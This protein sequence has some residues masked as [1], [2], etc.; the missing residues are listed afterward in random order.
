M[1]KSR[2]KLAVDA[3]CHIQNAHILGRVGKGFS[4]CGV[5][6]LDEFDGVL[7]EL[8][9][10]LGELTVPQA[11][12]SGLIFALDKGSEYSRGEIEVWMDSEFIVRQMNGTYA[13]RKSHI[14][15]FYDKVKSLE[16]RYLGGVKYFH[17]PRHSPLA[18]R[19]DRLAEIEYQK[20]RP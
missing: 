11:E 18:Q 17:H 12:Y 4:A 9:A 3:C 10:Y 6:V 7:A 15:E 14:K 5:L 13:L 1:P 2:I 19:A 8:S 20:H 16:P